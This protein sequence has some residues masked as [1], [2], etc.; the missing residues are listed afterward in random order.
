MKK[1]LCEPKT[2]ISKSQLDLNAKHPIMLY[3]KHHAV[4]LL[5]RIEH[6]DNQ[7]EGNEHVRNIVQQKM[8][9][10]GIRNALRS[11]K[12]TCVTCRKGRAQ[13]IAPLMADLPEEW[14]EAS[15]DFTNVGVDYFGSFIVKIGCR[16]EKRWCS[17]YLSN[18]ENGAYRSGTQ[19]G[20]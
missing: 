8:W 19:V 12:N 4:E 9:I 6:K 14:L 1:D 11:I 13:T 2:K 10:L 3:W 20:H 7:H 17:L 18:Y 5:L 16:N 15:T